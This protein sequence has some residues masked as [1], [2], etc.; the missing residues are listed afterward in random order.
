MANKDHSVKPK[1][2]ALHARLLGEQRLVLLAAA[3]AGL[4][5]SVNALRKVADLELAIAATENLL[6]EA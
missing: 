5:L 2:E 3:E 1:L 6:D 4:D